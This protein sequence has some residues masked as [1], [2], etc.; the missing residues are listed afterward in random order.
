M[1][2]GLLNIGAKLGT[3]AAM[4]SGPWGWVAWIWKNKKL[5]AGV[6]GWLLIGPAW[7]HGCS[8]GQNI[9][10]LENEKNVA[11]IIAKRWKAKVAAD[12]RDHAIA[13]RGAAI[14]RDRRKDLDNAKINIPDQGL[15][16]RQRANACAQLRRQ[17]KGC[18]SLAPA[19]GSPEGRSEGQRTP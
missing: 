19:I 4:A 1:I 15:T 10:R 17:G 6:L 5:I 18:E 14:I 7:L 8:H 13:T 16:A 2:K 3:K 12:R 11:A 9:E